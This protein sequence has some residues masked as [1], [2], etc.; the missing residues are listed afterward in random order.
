M[1]E[2]EDICTK[3]MKEC[4]NAVIE[5]G[6]KE[7]I[8]VPTM[9]LA[10]YHQHKLENGS[11]KKHIKSSNY[12]EFMNNRYNWIFDRIEET[13]KAKYEMGWKDA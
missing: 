6:L 9:Y 7:V 12:D 13:I 4:N 11:Y 3:R 2:L 5:L 10:L 8:C 1:S